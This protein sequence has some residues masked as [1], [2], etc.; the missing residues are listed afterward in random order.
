VDSPL[1][2]PNHPPKYD[3]W[4][5][6]FNWL[7]QMSLFTWGVSKL[8]DTDNLPFVLHYWDWHPKNTI[9]NDREQ[10]R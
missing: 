5:R 10:L 4:H 8:S 1:L 7:D 3:D 6:K 9:I 2:E